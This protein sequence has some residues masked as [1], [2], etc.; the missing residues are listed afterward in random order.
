[1][2]AMDV[3]VR[4]WGIFDVSGGPPR[5]MGNDC[6]CEGRILRQGLLFCV[7]DDAVCYLREY[8]LKDPLLADTVV[9]PVSIALRGDAF[10]ER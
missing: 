2:H 6:K 8:K 3:I 10:H 5:L 1:M 9:L 4:A 7:R